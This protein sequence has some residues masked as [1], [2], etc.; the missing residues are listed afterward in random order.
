MAG[1]VVKGF[2]LALLVASVLLVV[3]RFLR[4]PNAP[5]AAVLC[6]FGLF[7][8]FSGWEHGFAREGGGFLLAITLWFL[9]HLLV[10]V[11]LRI[12]SPVLDRILSR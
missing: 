12:V 2:V 4:M 3:F 10:M 1:A 5:F 9:V 11:A 8:A 6:S 7:V